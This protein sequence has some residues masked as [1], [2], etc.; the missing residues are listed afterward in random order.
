MVFSLGGGNQFGNVVV[1][2][3]P[4]QSHRSRLRTVRFRGGRR[5]DFIQAHAQR[6]VDHFLEWFP[7][8][9]SAFLC[10]GRNVGIK[11]QRGSHAG[12]MMLSVRKSTHTS[13]NASTFAFIAASILIRGG[14]G[15]L[16]PSPGNFFVASMPS[17][18]PAQ[19]RKRT[20]LGLCMTAEREQ[21][22][23]ERAAHGN[24]ATVNSSRGRAPERS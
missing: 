1:T 23:K 16:K 8:F 4:A 15:R 11:R 12:I 13:R 2:K 10:F 5:Q 17:L 3:A 6:G 19:R 7:Q 14:R 22:L 18:L 24:N 20:S 9:G 21:C